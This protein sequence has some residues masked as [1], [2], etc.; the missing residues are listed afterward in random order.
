M[1]EENYTVYGPGGLDAGPENVVESG[2]RQIPE[3][4]AN[5]RILKERAKQATT[6]NSTFLAIGA[7]TNAQTLAQVRALTRQV[8]ALIRIEITDTLNIADS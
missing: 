7:P 8:N 3:Y 4:L 6:S 1:A 2:I 5:L